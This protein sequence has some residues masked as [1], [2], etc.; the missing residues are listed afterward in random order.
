MA[1]TVKELGD[2]RSGAAVRRL[3]TTPAGRTFIADGNAY[4]NWPGPRI[5]DSAELLGAILH[6]DRFPAPAGSAAVRWP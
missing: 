4:F 5:A 6:P 3:R 2:D 1:G